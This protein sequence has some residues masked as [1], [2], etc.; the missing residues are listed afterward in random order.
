MATGK[1]EFDRKLRELGDHIRRGWA[2]LH[3]MP[4]ETKEKVLQEVDQ[5]WEKERQA[6]E[7]VERIDRMQTDEAHAA[8]EA[9]HRSKEAEEQKKRDQ[10]DE[11]YGHGHGH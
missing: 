11:Q 5:Q 3:P 9:E 2:K 8:Q 1:S 7:L 4:D 6:R 10:Q